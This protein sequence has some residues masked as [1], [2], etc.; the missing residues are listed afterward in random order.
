MIPQE[1][2]R[3]HKK[4]FTRK[5][6]RAIASYNMIREGEPVCVALSGGKDSTVLLY[7]LWYLNRYCDISFPLAAAHIKTAD[8]D[9]SVLKSLC[10]ELGVEYLEDEIES[11]AQGDES[12]ICYLCSR[13]KRG[14]LRKLVQSHN[15]H[16]L[17][18]GHHADDVAE[19]FFMNIV[20]SAKLGSFSPTVGVPGSRVKLI[21]PMIYLRERTIRSIHSYLQLPLLDYTCPHEPTSRR[22]QLKENMTQLDGMFHTTDFVDKLVSSLENIDKTNLWENCGAG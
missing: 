15:I 10:R 17:A 12:K 14:A 1:Y 9:T 8:Y 21:R 19:T 20:H 18:Y 13:L 2:N 16:V 3:N 11:K 6:L 7:I 22:M 5:C 4:W